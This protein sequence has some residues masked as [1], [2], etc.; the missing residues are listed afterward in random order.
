MPRILFQIPLPNGNLP[1]Y[2]A[3][4]AAFVGIMVACWLGSRWARWVGISP[5][6]YQSAVIY[7]FLCVVAVL[8]VVWHF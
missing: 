8:W 7:L 5:R 3:G 4:V 6:T 1:V 2:T